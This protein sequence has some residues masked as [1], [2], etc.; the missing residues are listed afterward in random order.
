MSAL[1]ELN[2][3]LGQK[4]S[5]KPEED[6][7]VELATV[8][9]SKRSNNLSALDQALQKS[10]SA[11]SKPKTQAP[12]P[13]TSPVKEE[14]QGFFA[15]ALGAGK[16]AIKWGL[17]AWNSLQTRNDKASF[18]MRQ[19][20]YGKN[21]RI[22]T[23]PLTGKKK[24]TNDLLD[25]YANAST[26]EQRTAVIRKSEQDIPL[27]KMLNSPTGKKVIKTVSEATS[28]L[29]LKAAATLSAIG[30]Q[31]Y[32]EAYSA[33]L[34]ERNDPSNPT[35]QKFLYELQDT[36]VQTAVGALLA[37][38]TSIATRNP[39]AGMAVSGAFYTAL[40]A[41]EQLQ[42]RGKVESGGNI[43]IDVVGDAVLNRLLLRVFKE[44]AG[45][46]WKTVAHGFGTEGSTEVAQS[47]LKYANDYGNARSEQ[48]KQAVLDKA[49]QYVTS[50]GI[51]MEFGVGGVAGGVITGAG[52]LAGRAI[53]PSQQPNKGGTTGGAGEGAK[54]PVAPFTVPD[55]APVG[56]GDREPNTS[57]FSADF[58]ENISE[59]RDAVANLQR[60]GGLN[61]EAR[62]AAEDTLSDYAKLYEDRSVYV[63]S[64]VSSAPLVQ[65]S[66]VTFP[67]G[68]VAMRFSANTPTQGIATEYD[69][70]QLFKSQEAATASAQEAILAWANTQLETTTNP[71][72]RQQLEKVISFAD[73]PR[74]P[75]AD[76]VRKEG[77]E[78][79]RKTIGMMDD[80]K[81]Y[82]PRMKQLIKEAQEKGE[83]FPFTKFTP[84]EQAIFDNAWR[85]AI[86]SIPVTVSKD[87]K[88]FKLTVTNKTVDKKKL[89]DPAYFVKAY[90]SAFAQ[91]GGDKAL[92][93]TL[94]KELVPEGKEASGYLADLYKKNKADIKTEEKQ[95]KKTEKKEGEKGTQTRQDRTIDAFESSSKQEVVGKLGTAQIVLGSYGT[96]AITRKTGENKQ[97]RVELKEL[98]AT[99]A[100][101]REAL[102]AGESGFRKDNLVLIAQM[103]DGELRAIVTRQ[104]KA[105]QEEVINFFRIGKNYQKFVDNLRSFGAPE[106]T[107]TSTLALE[108]Q[109]SIQLAYGGS[110][111]S[112]A[113]ASGSIN[114]EEGTMGVDRKF[115]GGKSGGS[116]ASA[117]IWTNGSELLDEDA[118]KAAKLPKPEK[119]SVV[120][121]GLEYVRAVEMPELVDL[122][123]TLM[124]NV[125]DVVKKTGDASG[126]FYAKGNGR[127]KL[128]AEL[129]KQ[130]GNALEAGR[131]LAHEIGHLIDYL[132]EGTLKRGNN[133]GRLF[134]LRDF[135]ST[136]F[137]TEGSAF[138]AEQR[139]EIR[140]RITKDVLKRRNIP[141]GDMV[142]GKLD[143]K[144]KKAVTNEVKKLYKKEVDAALTKGGY[145]K[146]ETLRKELLTVTR[147]W[148]PYDPKSVPDSY[149]K[150]RESSVELYAEA[151]SVLLNAPTRLQQMA[152][153]FY[154]KF[155]A[156]L[157]AK[158]QVRDAYFELQ[159]LLSGDRELLVKKRREGVQKMFE[160]GDYKAL[161]LDKKRF[162]E[163]E[164]R[165][166]QY[167]A[168]FK[169]HIVDKNY[170]IID[171]VRELNNKGT[172]LTPDE[173]PVFFLEERNYLGGKI[174]ALFDGE[175]NNVYRDVV[176]TH[177]IPWTTFGEF[178]FYT[179]IA[180]GDRSDVANPR[181]ITPDAAKEALENMAVE[182][183]KENV[184]V[185]IKN[186]EKFRGAIKAVA[187]EAYESGLYSEELYKQMI[188][189]PA[190]VTFQ[191]LDHLEDGMTSR[192]YK[193]IGTLKDI[194][195]P[196]DSS[197]LKVITTIRATERNNVTKSVV[198]FLEKN[199]AG[200]ISEAKYSG[201]EKGRRPL[202]SKKENEELITF[203]EG[204][205]MK[206]YYVDPY[207]A[208][209]INNESVGRVLAEITGLR[210]MNSTLFR[211]LFITFNLGFQ[212]FNFIRD[213]V[214][215]WKNIPD[216]TLARAAKRYIQAGKIARVRAFGARKNGA[217]A[218]IE[219]QLRQL[220]DERV[221]S[222]TFGDL[223]AGESEFDSQVEKIL[224]GTG[225]KDFQPE[226]AEMRVP[227][228]AKPVVKTLDKA[229]VLTVANSI[230][231][232]IKQIGDFIE[233]LPKAAGVY[234]FQSKAED[235]KLTR[236]QKSYIRRKLG[237]P[238]FLAGGTFK[239]FTNE[240]FLFSNAILQ[241]IRADVEVATDPKTRS[242]FWWK[243]SK[244]VVVPKLLMFAA[245]LGLFGR[246][247]KDMFDDVSEYD[248][249]NY[250]IIPLGKD[251]NDKT[252]YFRLPADESSRF[253]G[254]LV[255]KMLNL[256]RSNQT[257]GRN[258]A[259]V[260]S[261]TG[262]Q[263]PSLSP[264]ISTASAIAQYVS[265]KNPYDAFRGRE[266]LSED[267][268]KAGG[269]ESAK[270]FA[271]WVFQQMGGGI[272]YRFYHEPVTPKAESKAE[273]I[274]NLP[275][276]G[277]ILG[278]FIRVSDFGQVEKL[279][280][281]KE[282]TEKE[283]ARARIEQKNLINKYIKDA[284][285]EGI[286]FSTMEIENKLIKEYLGK[287]APTTAD[288]REKVNRLRKKF[289]LSFK[290]GS[291]EPEVLALMDATT[292]QQKLDILKQIEADMSPAEFRTLQTDLLK[293]GIVSDEVF[294]RLRSGK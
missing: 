291:A 141:F 16:S 48:E 180:A 234:E 20:M 88:P 161:E 200:E 138:T 233:T 252:V 215:F 2:K 142:T 260:V 137:G 91:G 27:I 225:I 265:G 276:L 121:G 50:G 294:G 71:Q 274:V 186:A 4:F 90:E 177:D 62:I 217:D 143:A 175:F 209:S 268:F 45:A 112:V 158:P 46:L 211:P 147:W 28:N 171:R 153:T 57:G 140:N 145:I 214:R 96:N 83:T 122:A 125:P 223:I 261:Y 257:I 151:L 206:G 107:R 245:L 42:E 162:A 22:V 131:T 228:F 123:R 133:L 89:K 230:L 18:E 172:V 152:P 120:M 169:H 35:W 253:I 232:T 216:M 213:F 110:E 26:A 63:P 224:A 126:R 179:R 19:I 65:V 37:L 293:N 52:T 183:G 81:A 204:G 98:P 100:Q 199:F 202:P 222:I 262:G 156:A 51:L 168:N 205:K 40:S 236:E 264:T 212:S 115:H 139:T 160:D 77:D 283:E 146:D 79:V 154:S 101:V 255:W 239:P 243:T 208:Q 32:D 196:A 47:L 1:D 53:N 134:T 60:E 182:I 9:Y 99:V 187:T 103:S 285:A 263:L 271:G 242:A 227:R 104:N 127:I 249:T 38:G 36:G 106:R 279:R 93:S 84:E 286:R 113:H 192:V 105:G 85:E 207:I 150:Y 66:T 58:S 73:E 163:K 11:E 21:N 167:W 251:E 49:K 82:T 80:N 247:L 157:D 92:Y 24:L 128:V 39:K 59:L 30:D 23:D 191:V 275:L 34:A 102:K 74:A 241:G 193:S 94:V 292:N 189:N 238:D 266:V 5:S 7:G 116:F 136:T 43:A 25:E 64:D 203:F 55:E 178:L 190:Y 72:E 273:Q 174:K 287:P 195:N 188:E 135:M 61:N 10:F 132:P 194:A 219:E 246:G 159:T 229:G 278:R 270:A 240:V 281:I 31:I 33:Y 78:R 155:F 119:E 272:F 68:K 284:R 288:E 259:D 3:A 277:N 86:S 67:D 173:N 235:G 170:Q 97:D 181:G 13:E 184:E 56:G 129:F 76:N 289:R 254:G 130:G 69:Y 290:R 41:D 165:R 149:R 267:V 176:N 218:E 8:D 117:G 237:S 166:R 148:H 197:M 109:S 221:F 6:G 14:P 231:D 108:P 12:L 17:D 75:I 198:K 144:T 250:T 114:A 111:E 54:E 44:P 118:R 258:I 244:V 29:P 185:L 269:S 164:E 248:M 210:F 124:G 256:G 87:Y 70:N 15:K 201:S 95:E 280:S 226:P 282:Q 220:E